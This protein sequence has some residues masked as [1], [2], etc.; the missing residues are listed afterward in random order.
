MSAK[1]IILAWFAGF[2]G[3]QSTA[4]LINIYLGEYALTIS[5]GV[6]LFVVGVGNIFQSA[7]FRRGRKARLRRIHD[8]DAKGP[9]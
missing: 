9:E 1:D 2:L 5:L 4:V 7:S 6:V 8:L 3:G